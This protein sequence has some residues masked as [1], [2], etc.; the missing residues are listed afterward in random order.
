MGLVGIQVFW[1]NRTHIQHLSVQSSSVA[2]SCPTLRSHE[3]Q[4]TRPPCPS[5]TPG[6]PPNPCPLSPEYMCVCTHVCV[7]GIRIPQRRQ[8]LEMFFTLQPQLYSSLWAPILSF[9]LMT[10]CLD[11]DP[12]IDSVCDE[13]HREG[14]RFAWI[15]E[16]S[17]QAADKSTCHL[18]LMEVQG[19]Y[20]HQHFSFQ[21][22]LPPLLPVAA[23]ESKGGSVS[24]RRALPSISLLPTPVFLGFPCGSAGK[25]ST[26][27]AGDLDSIPGLGRS[28][29]EGKGYPLELW[30]GEFHGLYSSWGLCRVRKGIVKSRTRLSDFH[31]NFHFSR[32]S[33]ELLSIGLQRKT[34]E[35]Y[36]WQ[37]TN[38]CEPCLT[39][40]VF[41]LMFKMHSHVCSLELLLAFWKSVFIKKHPGCRLEAPPVIFPIRFS[42]GNLIAAL[43]T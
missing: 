4:H 14:T 18:R 22:S 34:S 26:C 21:A 3:P 6:V 29:G 38:S 12:L 28:P 30:P 20:Q 9:T 36:L 24:G 7:C 35:A 5:P 42:E 23:R 11:P 13:W 37:K 40:R 33:W 2:Q 17:L 32:K 39:L 25:E 16:L 8:P 10:L 19:I 15:S 1:Q 27:N 43:C 41:I 31:F